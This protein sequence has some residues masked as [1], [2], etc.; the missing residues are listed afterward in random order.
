MRKHP[1]VMVLLLTFFS[2]LAHL[3]GPVR[4][5]A[6][7]D[8]SA[9]CIECHQQTGIT[10]TFENGESVSG[11]VDVGAFRASVH[12]SLGCTACHA[13]FAGKR[14]PGRAYKSKYRYQL[15][16]SLT[17][18]T[19]HA[20]EQI[21][22]N[23]IHQV[24]FREENGGKPVLCVVCHG[25]HTVARVS[26]KS[27]FPSEE[28][29][30]MRCH[31]R[32]VTMRFRNGTSRVIS[33]DASS[34]DSSVHGKLS[35][36]D[37]HFGFS[38]EEHP[39]RNF[40]SARDLTLASSEICR[41]CHFDKYTKTLESIHYKMLSQG[42][43]GAPVC[44]DCHGSHGIVRM[45]KERITSAQRCQRCHADV[46]NRYAQSVHGNALVNQHNQDVPVCVDCHTAHT[47]EDPFSSDY[48]ER[49]PEIC[50]A[51]HARK[52]LMTKYGLS[53]E[54]VNTYLSDFHGITLSLYR[55]QK[56]D[57]VRQMRPIALC[58]DCHGT[59]GIMSA[60]GPG[61]LS[62]KAK[63]LKR[64]QKCHKDAT[65]NFPD[66]WLSH[67]EPS[68]KRTPIV[69]LAG[70]AYKAFIPFLIIGLALQILLHIWRYAVNR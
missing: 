62:V 12:G 28:R 3:P 38:Q 8:T 22:R 19:C 31:D 20:D 29:Y 61:S 4:A 66:A 57:Q 24:M 70:L 52:D 69:F 41:R 51:C 26:R 50:S 60:T 27:S 13:E 58:T 46:Y 44:V 45:S 39:R 16:S 33:I 7:R 30:C 17:C 68:L 42:N 36:S 21:R 64:C 1:V 43:T 40:T 59:H 67:Y 49:I 14:H 10:T 34:L 5:G 56:N 23:R 47:I 25:F 2:V 18:R 54:V 55:R 15:R 63:L 9:E 32:S 53:T 35:C 48:R 6:S 65:E 11:M 37:C